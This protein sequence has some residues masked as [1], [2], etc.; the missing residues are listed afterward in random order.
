MQEPSAWER[1]QRQIGVWLGKKLENLVK[2]IER[3]PTTSQAIF[4]AGA[5]GSLAFIAFQLF[6]LFR[7][8]H[9]STAPVPNAGALVAQ[10]A[11][12][13]LAAARSAAD[14]GDLNRAIQC[15][16]WAA[17]ICLQSAGTLPK[18]A[19][20]TPREFLRAIQLTHATQHLRSL[21]AALERFWYGRLPATAEDFNAF[22]QSVE[23]LG[24]KLD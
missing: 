6:R 22:L 11:T 8:G 3:H 2:S 14:G 18:S 23:A 17:I 9:S 12:E 7:T 13:W 21:T 4:W 10:N 19:G 15:S 24:C 16:Y 5:L 20:H 1:W